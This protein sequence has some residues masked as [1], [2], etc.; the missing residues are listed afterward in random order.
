M[1]R[2]PYLNDLHLLCLF[3]LAVAQPL[4]DVLSKNPQFFVGRGNHPPELYILVAAVCFLF[5]GGLG[6]IRHMLYFL[7][8][9]FGR[10]FH[11]ALLWIL[12]V[13][14]LV[15]IQKQVISSSAKAIV[16]TSALL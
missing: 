6:L 8:E 15:L 4:L 16:L 14:I 10:A 1:N 12:F 2:N 5:P 3:C 13:V 7:P 9:G 11:G